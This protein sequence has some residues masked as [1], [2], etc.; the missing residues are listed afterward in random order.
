MKSFSIAKLQLRVEIW[1]L[2]SNFISHFTGM[3][4]LIHAGIQ[5]NLR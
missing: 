4:L 1:E 5:V 3:W 2:M